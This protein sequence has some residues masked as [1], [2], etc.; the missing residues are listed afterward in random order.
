M[1][2]KKT[3]LSS[4]DSAAIPSAAD[5]RIGIVVA[6][7]NPEVTQALLSAAQ[8][9]LFEHGLRA[10]NL[11]VQA[12][13]GSFELP[14]GAQFLLEKHKP[15]A[16]IILGCVIQGETRHF[17]FICQGVTEGIMS[18]NLEYKTPVIFG[19]LTTQ[20]Q[21]QAMARSGGKHGN[22]GIEAAITAIRIAALW[23]NYSTDK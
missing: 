13:P 15:D 2:E 10:A 3:N 6:E 18:L 21:E 17:D 1:S 23:Q 11:F 9:S 12:V 22:K 16:V 19:L 5:M 8:T 4:Y 14:S 20:N 7:W